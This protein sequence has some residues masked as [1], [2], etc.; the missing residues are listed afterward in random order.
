[1]ITFRE[2]EKRR[3]GA[4]GLPLERLRKSSALDLDR[5]ELGESTKI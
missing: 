1:M 2:G 4:F 3:C 5:Y